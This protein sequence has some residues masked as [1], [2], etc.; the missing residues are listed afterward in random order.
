MKA[1]ILRGSHF[2]ELPLEPTSTMF[3]LGK[4]YA[5][6]N[7]L[8]AAY[9]LHSMDY[10]KHQLSLVR[11]GSTVFKRFACFINTGDSDQIKGILP[12]PLLCLK[13]SCSWASYF[14]HHSPSL[15][16]SLPARAGHKFL[17]LISEWFQK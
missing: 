7:I 3:F 12:F 17:L 13:V 15:S 1:V 2:D 4:I 16:R 11:N 10:T 14:L 8:N 5:S 6:L 9:V